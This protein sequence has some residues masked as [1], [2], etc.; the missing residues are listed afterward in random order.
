MENS[1]NYKCKVILGHT[2]P[3]TMLSTSGHGKVIMFKSPPR[4]TPENPTPIFPAVYDQ[5]KSV[6]ESSI[7]QQ[8]HQ[9]HHHGKY[10]WQRN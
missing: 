9:S 1:N 2:P 5:I 7:W 6:E 8:Q 3:N 10:L 4:T